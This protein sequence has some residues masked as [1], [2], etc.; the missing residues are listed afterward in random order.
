MELLVLAIHPVARAYFSFQ[1]QLKLYF[2][3]NRNNLYITLDLPT[4]PVG[5]AHQP[6]QG[7]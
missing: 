4:R 5:T 3:C 6:K 2:N 1:M 7:G